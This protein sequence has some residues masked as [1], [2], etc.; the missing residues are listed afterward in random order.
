MILNWCR[1][2]A[3]HRTK[4]ICMCNV[5]ACAMPLY[6]TCHC[7]YYFRTFS[8]DYLIISLVLLDKQL[9]LWSAECFDNCSYSWKNVEF[10]L[11]LILLFSLLESTSACSVGRIELLV[12]WARQMHF[13]KV[14][15]GDCASRMASRLLS[16]IV[17]GRGA[18]IPCEMVFI[19]VCL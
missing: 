16:S 11:N 17:Q 12:R 2:K 9:I 6:C 8:V 3:Y 5:Y 18:Q 10:D 7:S 13:G 15:V 19:V 14:I 4:I 1:V